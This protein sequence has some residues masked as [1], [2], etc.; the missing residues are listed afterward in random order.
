VAELET[1]RVQ[2]EP[3][4]IILDLYPATAENQ[5]FGQALRRSFAPFR[6]L[7]EA[8]RMSEE[9]ALAILARA[10]S[11][12]VV[13][14]SPTARFQGYSKTDWENWLLQNPE[15]FHTL[16]EIAG[17]PSRWE[18]MSHGGNGS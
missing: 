14:G 1:V 17:Q 7:L 11:E 10:F 3:E 15:I 8:E 4:G 6:L 13:A 2:F 16:V 12:S 9:R 18:E 5:A